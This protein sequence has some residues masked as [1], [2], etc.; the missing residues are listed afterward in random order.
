[1]LDKSTTLPSMDHDF[2]LPTRPSD[3]LEFR[4]QENETLTQR[5]LP[6][7]DLDEPINEYC[8]EK[9]AEAL[10]LAEEQRR[11]CDHDMAHAMKEHAE[12]WEAL[13][14]RIDDP[15]TQI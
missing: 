7:H 3:V 14:K 13:A 4:R 12:I 5:G 11:L 9:Q 2:A 10:A 8:R 6:I 1:M 15:R